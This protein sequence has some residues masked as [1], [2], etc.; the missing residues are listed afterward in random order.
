M[1][2]STTVDGDFHLDT[3]PPLV[4]AH[5][6]QAFMAGTWTQ[7]DE[8]HGSDVVVVDAPGEHDGAIGDAAVT[9]RLG[10]VLS[11][12]VGDCAPVVLVGDGDDGQG[13]V[14]V[15]HAGWKGA[16]DGVLQRAVE[17][18]HAARIDA[19]LGPC[20]HGCCNEFGPDLLEQF[21]RRFGPQVASTTT[22]GT[23]SLHL[24]A[25][26]AAALDEVGVAVR[27]ES[28]CTRCSTSW[29]S[30]RRGDVGRHVMCV[31]MMV[32]Q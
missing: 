18:M 15:A 26:V 11:V 21:V 13:V 1:R 12:W 30:H 2:T 3:V 25:V 23:P 32:V 10:T 7:L 27:D 17:A 4:L 28:V 24:P 16:L 14:G 6:R 9:R 31:R 22:W 29:F 8:V 20:I 5:R 19:V